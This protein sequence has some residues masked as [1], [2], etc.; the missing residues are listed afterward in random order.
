MRKSTAAILFASILFID[1]MTAPALYA[2]GSQASSGS[3]MGGGHKGGSRMMSHCGGMMQSD[4]GSGRP[5][6]QWRDG[7]SPTPDDHN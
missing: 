6:D 5:N 7:R 2:E 3:M 4:S 1:A